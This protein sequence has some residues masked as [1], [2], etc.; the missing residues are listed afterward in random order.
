M[1]IQPESFLFSNPQLAFQITEV[2]ENLINRFVTIS[3]A[4]GFEINYT[5]F[6]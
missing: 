2:D 3:Y 4:S 5:T 1:A 6:E